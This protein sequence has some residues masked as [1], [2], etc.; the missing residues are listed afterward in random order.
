[1]SNK[2]CPNENENEN[3]KIPNSIQSNRALC[4]MCI[5][6]ILMVS[7]KAAAQHTRSSNWTNRTNEDES[8]KSV[9]P[10][11]TMSL[12]THILTLHM[13]LTLIQL[14][15]P[16]QKKTDDWKSNKNKFEC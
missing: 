8:N 15:E 16:K 3:W 14:E 10:V 9:R 2:K 1:M 6:S 11:A 4:N 7:C 12:H 13:Q 5:K